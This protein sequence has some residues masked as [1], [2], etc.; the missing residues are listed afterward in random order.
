MGQPFPEPWVYKGGLCPPGRPPAPGPPPRFAR[1]HSA[2]S[3]RDLP[4]AGPSWARSLRA[5][6][7]GRMSGRSGPP[8]PRW[9]RVSRHAA[10]PGRQGGPAVEGAVETEVLA[11]RGAE[12]EVS[13][14]RGAET[15]VLALRGA[16]TAA[17]WRGERPLTLVKGGLCP[18]GRPPAPGPPPRFARRHSARSPRDLPQAGPSW[19]RSLRASGQGRMSGRSG[20]P[21]PRWCRVSRH[22]AGPGRQGGPAVEGAVETEVLALR[23]AET[24]VS[25][26]RGAETEVLA[27]RGAETAAG[28]RGE[29]PLTLVKGDAVPLD[30]P[31]LPVLHLAS[32]GATPLGRPGTS[33][34][35]VPPGLGRCGRPA[36]AGCRAGRDRPSRDGARC[37][38]VQRGLRGRGATG[39]PGPWRRRS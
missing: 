9:C 19:A 10:G 28:W 1:R 30:D 29:R 4:Q 25:A 16:E 35:R 36:R 7:Q 20:P 17:G 12:T 13:A 15:E 22:A 38:R 39:G 2:R 24:E 31:L 18:P 6:G 37:R 33:R 21:F 5:S 23:G 14:L 26:L 11:L 3:P 8:F 27:L 34:K 32:R